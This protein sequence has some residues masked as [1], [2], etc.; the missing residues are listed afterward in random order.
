MPDLTWQ[1]SSYSAQGNCLEV[2]RY[3]NGNIL[4][5]NVG[6]NVPVYPILEATATEWK[7]FLQGVKAGEF[8]E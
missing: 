6:P 5:R 4:L 2:A 3:P 7:A 8:D 1:K